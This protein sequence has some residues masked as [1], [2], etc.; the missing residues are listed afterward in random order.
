MGIRTADDIEGIKI[1]DAIGFF[2]WNVPLNRVYGD[3]VVAEVFAISCKDL[4]IG[5]PIEALIQHV[6]E[7][8]R[9]RLAKAIHDAIITGM[10]FRCEYRV[11]HPG[12]RRIRI[13][14]NGRCFRDEQGV[15]SIYSGTVTLARGQGTGTEAEQD[16]DPLETHCRAALGL[17]TTRHHALAARYISSALNVLGSN[18]AR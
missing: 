6:D 10:P 8:D 11:T 16:D 18:Q 7:G 13:V 1:A 2:S 5:A 4:S 12:G 3:E 15:P 14:A 17:A 9:Q